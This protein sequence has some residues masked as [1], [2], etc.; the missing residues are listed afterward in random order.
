MNRTVYDILREPVIS[1]KSMGLLEF[2]KRYTFKVPVD[3]NKFQIKQAV[4]QVFGVK[5]KKINTMNYLG[6]YKRMGVHR[7]KRADWKKAIV[8][9]TDDSKSIE[10]FEGI[11]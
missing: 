6:K 11:N 9:L 2:G 4:E 5:V 7:G 3:A 10:Y 1:E 8:T